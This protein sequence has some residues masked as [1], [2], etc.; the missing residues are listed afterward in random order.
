MTGRHVRKGSRKVGLKVWLVVQDQEKASLET[1][2]YAPSWREEELQRVS[3]ENIED[4]REL[5]SPI[6][7]KKEDAD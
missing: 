7:P 4:A 5:K 6:F 1:A 2:A 3:V